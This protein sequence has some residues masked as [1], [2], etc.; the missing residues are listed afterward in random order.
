VAQ[1]SRVDYGYTRLIAEAIAKGLG[2]AD[3]VLVVS[4]NRADRSMGRRTDLLGV[5][6]PTHAHA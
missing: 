2:P 6:G 3:R 1:D 5:G 4:V